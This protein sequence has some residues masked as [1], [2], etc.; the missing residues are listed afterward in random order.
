MTVGGLLIR[1]TKKRVVWNPS[2]AK[3]YRRIL[4]K[5]LLL[6]SIR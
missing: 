6:Q 5:E 4:S 1:P 3:L 2:V